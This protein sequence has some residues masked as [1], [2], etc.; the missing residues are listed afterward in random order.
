ML[1]FTKWW[2]KEPD[3]ASQ[4]TCSNVG[5]KHEAEN[6][7]RKVSQIAVNVVKFRVSFSH[8]ERNRVD[9]LW[10]GWWGKPL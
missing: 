3:L 4:S 8:S 9:I 7:M 6:L 10:K 1:S 2:A 5:D